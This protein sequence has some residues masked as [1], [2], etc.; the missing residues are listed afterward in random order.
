[1]SKVYMYLYSD[2]SFHHQSS[3]WKPARSAELLAESLLI[4]CWREPLFLVIHWFALVWRELLCQARARSNL[5]A[6]YD[7]HVP[8]VRVRKF[9]H[10]DISPWN[11]QRNPTNK[12]PQRKLADYMELIQTD[13][14][15]VRHQV[16]IY[17]VV[18]TLST[19]HTTRI[20]AD[21]DLLQTQPESGT[22][23]FKNRWDVP[24]PSILKL[25]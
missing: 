17:A 10:D 8:S 25:P 24:F 20:S 11:G 23:H 12:H 21:S 4:D 9:G 5:G 16:L 13:I 22:L 6:I 18:V 7:R 14:V 15:F 1:M 2:S 3:L 19:L